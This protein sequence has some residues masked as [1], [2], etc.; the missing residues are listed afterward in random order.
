MSDIKRILPS[1]D[2]IEKIHAEYESDE[3]FLKALIGSCD[4]LIGPSES[5]EYV[6]SIKKKVKLNGEEKENKKQDKPGPDWRGF[7]GI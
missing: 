3:E 4:I 2:R 5:V 6:S 1:L 7:R